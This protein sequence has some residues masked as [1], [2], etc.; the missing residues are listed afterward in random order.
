M[1]S[2]SFADLLA[3]Y[4]TY[5]VGLA[6]I[7]AI[8]PNINAGQDAILT[9][10]NLDVNV[11]ID[12]NMEYYTDYYYFDMSTVS[13]NVEFDCPHEEAFGDF[14]DQARDTML[15]YAENSFNFSDMGSKRSIVDDLVSRSETVSDAVDRKIA[16]FG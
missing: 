6:C 14:F 5:M 7:K 9:N 3:S 10:T 4:K 8:I 1:A 11:D 2:Q 12:I 13:I 16:V 15:Y